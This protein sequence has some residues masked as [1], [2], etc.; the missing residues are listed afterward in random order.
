VDIVVLLFPI[1]LSLGQ[2]ESKERDFKEQKRSKVLKKDFTSKVLKN[3]EEKKQSKRGANR[4]V[5][6][7]LGC[8]SIRVPSTPGPNFLH[9]CLLLFVLSES[10][11]TASYVQ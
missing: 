9:V 1:N 8:V 4:E 2:T 11:V 7:Q 5:K 6:K 3:T 10:P